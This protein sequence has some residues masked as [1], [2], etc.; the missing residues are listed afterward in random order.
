MARG[1]V[2]LE[3]FSR[4]NP[5]ANESYDTRVSHLAILLC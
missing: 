4:G 1:L 5:K 2:Y 3:G